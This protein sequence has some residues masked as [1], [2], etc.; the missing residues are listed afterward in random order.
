VKQPIYKNSWRWTCKF[1]KHVVAIYEKKVIV[2][3]FASSWYIFLTYIYDARSHLYQSVIICSEWEG[4]FVGGYGDIDPV[5]CSGFQ[6]IGA[7]SVVTIDSDGDI[8][9][10]YLSV[11]AGFVIPYGCNGFEQSS[12]DVLV[13][14]DWFCLFGTSKLDICLTVHHQLGKVIQMN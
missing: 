14:V 5:V 13:L 3:L 7:L 6:G 4:Y 11:L 8:V 10:W 2:K 9:W 1:P 12:F